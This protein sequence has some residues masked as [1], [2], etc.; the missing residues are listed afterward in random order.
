MKDGVGIKMDE[1]GPVRERRYQNFIENTVN[2]YITEG[3]DVRKL[4]DPGAPDK[5]NP[6]YLGSRAILDRFG[7]GAK[8]FGRGQANTVYPTEGELKDNPSIMKAYREG[9]FG[10]FGTAEAIEAAKQYSIRAGLGMRKQV[11]PESGVP[12][13]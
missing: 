9:R 13:R 10:E 11:V 8:P 1:E 7:A 2:D 6:E 3:K 12:V 4:F 5:P